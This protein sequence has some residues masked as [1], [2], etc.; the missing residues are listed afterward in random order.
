MEPPP[1]LGLGWRAP[2]VAWLMGVERLAEVVGNGV[3]GGDGAGASL[4][5]VG[6]VTAGS[7]DEF[8][9]D[10]PVRASI[11]RGTAKTANTIVR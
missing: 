5:L 4:D 11:Q 2:L 10:R 1:R 7:A 9:I 3:G 8:P 6:A